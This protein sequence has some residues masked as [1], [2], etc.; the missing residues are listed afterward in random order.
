MNLKRQIRRYAQTSADKY[1]VDVNQVLGMSRSRAVL[2]ARRH[3]I[4][5]LIRYTGCSQAQVAE[6]WGIDPQTVSGAV[7]D[8]KPLRQFSINAPVAAEGA[9]RAKLTWQYG[10]ERAQAILSGNDVATQADIARWNH[11]GRRVAA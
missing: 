6:A 3:A 7:K 11:L 10:P 8:S 2:I 5:K 4:R 1:G 9:V